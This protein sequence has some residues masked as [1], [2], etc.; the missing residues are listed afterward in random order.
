MELRRSRRTLAPGI[1]LLVVGVLLL[2]SG[3]TGETSSSASG[4]VFAGIALV[5]GGVFVARA[6]KPFRFRIGADGLTLRCNGINRLVRWEEI[7]TVVLT[8]PACDDSTVATQLLLIPANGTDLGV[9]MAYRSPAD[10]RACTMILELNEV[11]ESP[12]QL[13]EALARFGEGRFTDARQLRQRQIWSP[14]FTSGM[15]GYDKNEVD[16]LIQQ[17]H[18]ALASGQASKCYEAR[19]EIDNARETLTVALRGYDRQQVDVF[20]SSLSAELADRQS[21]EQPK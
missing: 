6:F 9:S 12:D 20:L 5:V 3:R 18:D 15:R 21:G 16:Q 14:A 4:S 11:K 7:D 13:A 8:Q 19:A 10:G 1:F 17:G 2:L